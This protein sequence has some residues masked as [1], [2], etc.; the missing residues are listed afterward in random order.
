MKRRALV[1][2]LLTVVL[3]GQ[4][5]RGGLLDEDEEL[6]KA[7]ENAEN[8]PREFTL[9]FTSDDGDTVGVKGVIEDDLRY[10]L[11][12][13]EGNV[14]VAELIVADDTLAARALSP[15]LIPQL[16]GAGIE[17]ESSFGPVIEAFRSGEWVIDPS[18]AP[19]VNLLVTA[20]EGSEIGQ[21]PIADA[22][23]IFAYFRS[24]ISLAADV[25]EWNEE[26]INPA[27]RGVEETFD[28]PSLGTTR[29][30]LVRPRLPR[31][32]TGQ[33]GSGEPRLLHFRKMA[34]YVRSGRVIKVV[35]EIEYEKHIEFRRAEREGRPQFLLD[36]RERIRAGETEEDIVPRRLTLEMSF[37]PDIQV[38][39]PQ[40]LT[41]N[42]A[43]LFGLGGP[44]EAA[45][46]E[47]VAGEPE[48]SP[49]PE[50]G[51]ASPSP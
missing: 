12:L 13:A 23:G 27:Y 8:D 21:D 7:L 50:G 38:A 3:V 42:F 32:E 20:R 47:S 2:V 5:C 44:P 6:L 11:V 36:M 37:N 46:G 14:G 17:V 4:G 51:G 26:S 19:P 40:G 35:E 1:A 10:S 31:R 45:G 24:A 34:F 49:S 43:S 30:D 16:S 41:A 28:K 18:G 29:Y 15:D 48:P 25:Q 33:P 22:L 39:V 9:R